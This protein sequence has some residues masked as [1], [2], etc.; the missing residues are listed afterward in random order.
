MNQEKLL[1]LASAQALSYAE[2]FRQED[3]DSA[4]DDLRFET[5]A[6]PSG[7]IDLFAVGE[8]G[9]YVSDTLFHVGYLTRRGAWVETFCGDETPCEYFSG[10]A[11]GVGAGVVVPAVA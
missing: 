10:P 11:V 6:R 7:V 2:W 3:P 4:A 5:F 8:G 9:G 1:Q